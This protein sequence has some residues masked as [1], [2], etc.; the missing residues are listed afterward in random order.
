MDAF[1]W[2]RVLTPLALIAYSAN[3]LLSFTIKPEFRS[4]KLQ[5]FSNMS[6]LGCLLGWL[7]MLL[8]I[9]VKSIDLLVKLSIVGWLILLP[10]ILLS[11]VCVF[12]K[13][14]H[15]SSHFFQQA[16]QLKNIFCKYLKFAVNILLKLLQAVTALIISFLS[17]KPNKKAIQL[18]EDEKRRKESPYIFGGQVFGN[19]AQNVFGGVDPERDKESSVF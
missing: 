7:I 12:S 6:Y 15:D 9:S 17:R 19:P 14:Q 11:A 4:M 8:A 5:I 16:T 10:S 2:Y 18:E 13:L 3:F 1:D